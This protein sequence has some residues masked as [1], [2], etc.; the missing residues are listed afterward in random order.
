MTHYVYDTALRVA[1]EIKAFWE[2]LQPSSQTPDKHHPVT[3]LI[4]TDATLRAQ[5]DEFIDG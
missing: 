4:M 3:I 5:F 1:E 2:D